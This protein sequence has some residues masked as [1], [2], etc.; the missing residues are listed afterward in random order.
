MH[1]QGFPKVDAVGAA[2]TRSLEACLDKV[3]LEQLKWR[4][5]SAEGL[6]L[7]Y[8]ILLPPSVASQLLE[9]LESN[10][11]YF[12]GDLAK[13]YVYGKWHPIP[14]QQVAFGDSGMS[15]KFSGNTVPAMMWPPILLRVRDLISE[16]TGYYYNF[17]LV[18][19]YKNGTDYIAEHRDDE[20]DLDPVVPIASLSL[21]QA[22]DFVFKHRDA[23]KSGPEKKDISSVKLLLEH[24]SLLLMNPP[25]NKLWFHSLPRRKNCHGVRLNLTF[26]K[27]LKTP[28]T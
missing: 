6:D 2:Y 10:L 28:G 12:S 11:D 16:I 3:E 24:G 18:N 19:R 8:T 21:G 27:V 13:V 9:H 17:V 5:I 1:H 20:K 26:R 14:R 4:K 22:R 25:T 7:G 23:R 15:Y